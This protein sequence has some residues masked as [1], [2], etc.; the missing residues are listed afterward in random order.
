ML[1][2]A[3][4]LAGGQ[5]G[6]GQKPDRVDAV[7]A[8]YRALTSAAVHCAKPNDD[9]E[10][11]VCAR[12]DADRYRVPALPRRGDSVTERTAALTRDYGL[13]PCGQG[14]FTVNCGKAGVGIARTF[15]PGSGSGETRVTTDHKPGR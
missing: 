2:M 6:D 10:I 1:L 5:D 14:A 9:T 8:D 12:R 13:P 15:G 4:L 3:M 11:R 7:L